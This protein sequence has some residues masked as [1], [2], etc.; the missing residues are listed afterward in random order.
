MCVRR[1][2]MAICAVTIPM[3]LPYASRAQAPQ[4]PPPPSG[5]EVL[6][7]GPVHEAFAQVPDTTPITMPVI[8]TQPPNPIDEVPPEQ[9]PQ[10]ENVQW[11]P[12]Y[13]A[14]DQDQSSYIWVSGAWRAFPP[15]RQWVPGHWQQVAGGWQ[16]ISGLWSPLGQTQLVVQPVPPAV[17]EQQTIPPAPDATST[18]VPGTWIWE[19]NRYV[20]R[21]AFWVAYHPGWI[22]IPAH[23]I[24][25]P[26]GCIFVDGFWDY[27]L[28]NRGLL[29]APVRI[30]VA[31]LA[32]PNWVY[33][34]QYV[35]STQ[36]LLEALFVGPRSRHYYFGDYFGPRYQK[37][38]YVF[39][40]NYR[41]NRHTPDVLFSYYRHRPGGE[42]WERELHALHEERHKGHGPLPPH[43][44]VEQNR[45]IENLRRERNVNQTAVNRATVV[46]P[47]GQV[48][49]HG[50]KVVHVPKEQ[51]EQARRNT[52]WYRQVQHERQAHANQFIAKG[53]PPAERGRAVPPIRLPQA[54]RV[55]WTPVKT[56]P[57]PAVPKHVE[58]PR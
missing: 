8:P 40:A 39:W 56:P 4:P 22:W 21:P 45:V 20:W 52:E 24:W 53:R 16:W 7:R 34:P 27:P 30:A 49:A 55:A 14:W 32:Q 31:L 57:A 48:E 46:R 50:V 36:T 43:T 23:Y 58:R 54:P 42:R 15:D 41:L 11:I 38:G 1:F 10:G 25:V 37:L 19:A 3:L 47:L 12:G 35:V 26:S 13:W 51:H 44:L 17:P 29:F 2:I 9:R 6:S 28:E 33:T 18:Y 5:V